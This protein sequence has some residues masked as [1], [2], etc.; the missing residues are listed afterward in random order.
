MRAHLSHIS[1][2]YIVVKDKILFIIPSICR[3][4]TQ[5]AIDSLYAQTDDRWEGLIV[6]NDCLTNLKLG[7]KVK[8][9]V[10]EGKSAAGARNHALDLYEQDYTRIGYLDDDDSLSP[11]YVKLIYEKYPDADVV[12]FRSQTMRKVRQHR[13][14]KIFPNK[15]NPATIA[16]TYKSEK[17]LGIRWDESGKDDQ[18]FYKKLSGLDV[19]VANELGYYIR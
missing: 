19:V 4:S 17:G 15:A 7:D 6:F 12:Q 18:L 10:F 11:N 1:R 16:F 8:S 3:P 2:G 5:R 13:P 9:L 14:G